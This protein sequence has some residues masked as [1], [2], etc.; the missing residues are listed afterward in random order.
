MPDPY[1][2]GDTPADT[3]RLQELEDRL[4]RGS[5]ARERKE[6]LRDYYRRERSEREARDGGE[7]RY[8]DQPNMSNY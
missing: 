7:R 1:T 5:H 8:P 6:I 4:A 3:R 2:D